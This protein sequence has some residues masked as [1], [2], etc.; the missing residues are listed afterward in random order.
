MKEELITIIVPVYKVE[1]YLERCIESIINQTYN[2]L[3]IILVD[4]GSP[5]NCG[6]ICDEYQIR[7]KR[8]K[9]IHK[10]NGGVSAARNDGIAASTGQYIAFIDSDD[11]IKKEYIEK[12]YLNLK[13]NNCDISICS[14]VETND[15]TYPVEKN[16]EETYIYNSEQVMEKI[17]YQREIYTSVWCKL[18]KKELF[19]NIVFPTESN[20]GEDLA[21]VYKLITKSKKIVYSREKNYCYFQ[22]NNSLIKSRFKKQRMNCI[23][24]VYQIVDFVKSEYPYILP[25]AHNRLFMEA[26]FIIIQI[27]K[28]EYKDEYQQLK[29][30]IKKYRKEVLKDKKS[31][32]GYRIIALASYSGIGI[33]KIIFKLKK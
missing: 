12:L 8:I 16:K 7:D 33:I 20:I 25:A 13:K 32:K 11:Y 26:I 9:V 17:M 29:G 21:T 28:K 3:E 4:D 2:N 14:Y 31:K 19:G 6:K 23:N 24:Y 30:I 15:N 5:D 1:D 27:P 18:F 22:R 10:E